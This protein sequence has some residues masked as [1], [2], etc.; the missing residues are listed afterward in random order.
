MDIQKLIE[1]ARAKA[2]VNGD[3]KL[4]FDDLSELASKHGIDGKVVDDLKAKSD[5]NG[6]GKVDINDLQAGLGELK[7]T[8][9]DAA[10][11][12]AGFVDDLK[13]TLFGKK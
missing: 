13:N 10:K 3:G 8:L 11:D 1:D 6:D 4:T 12:P 2:D 5:T 9:G 7:T